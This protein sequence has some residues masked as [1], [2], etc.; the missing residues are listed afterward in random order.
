MGQYVKN[1]SESLFRQIVDQV[2]FGAAAAARV[3]EDTIFAE[4]LINQNVT[5]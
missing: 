1:G 4:A 5:I 3:D 2:I